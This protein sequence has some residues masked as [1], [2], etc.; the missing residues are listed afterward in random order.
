MRPLLFCKKKNRHLN[1]NIRLAD[2]VYILLLAEKL[3]SLLKEL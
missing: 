1:N 3:C 2:K